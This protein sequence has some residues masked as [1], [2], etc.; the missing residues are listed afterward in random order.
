[1][2]DGAG[3]ASVFFFDTGSG[4]WVENDK[5]YAPDGVAGGQFGFSVAAVSGTAVVVGAPTSNEA[6]LYEYSAGMWS[7][8]ATYQSCPTKIGQNMASW[9]S[10]VVTGQGSDV[11]LDTSLTNV[12]GGCGGN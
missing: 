11:V 12:D 8:A 9:S 7:L 6:Y 3:A 4:T 2:A 5:L 10:L 1:V